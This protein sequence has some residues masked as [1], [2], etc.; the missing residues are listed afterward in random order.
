MINYEAV[1]ADLEARK[2]KLETMI[3]EQSESFSGSPLQ[4]H[5]EAALVVESLPRGNR[6]MMPSL[7]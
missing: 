6:R 3:A 7:A 2:A 4:A 5:L 1:L